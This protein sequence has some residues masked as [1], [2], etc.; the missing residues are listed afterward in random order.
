[1]LVVKENTTSKKPRHVV[2]TIN[3]QVKIRQQLELLSRS[4]ITLNMGFRRHFTY[5]FF[6]HI[7]RYVQVLLP[8]GS[9]IIEDALYEDI[10]LLVR[11]STCLSSVLFILE[12]EV[13]HK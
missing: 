12:L 2:L 7:R 5:L 11:L 3:Q 9:R 6:F 10:Y 8:T 13:K 1:M 4:G